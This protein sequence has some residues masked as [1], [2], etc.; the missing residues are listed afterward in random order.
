[1][2]TDG[3]IDLDELVERLPGCLEIIE[4]LI[5]EGHIYVDEKNLARSRP[6]VSIDPR[7]ALHSI[8]N[9]AHIASQLALLSSRKSIHK[10][11]LLQYRRVS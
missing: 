5:S 8:A 4:E 3:G 2:L 7:D 6:L 10:G 11:Y 9:K 1:M